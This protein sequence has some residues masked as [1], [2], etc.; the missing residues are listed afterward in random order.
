[1]KI[2]VTQDNINCGIQKD[3]Y[4]CPVSIALEHMGFALPCVSFR[5]IHFIKEP[6]GWAFF[7]TPEIVMKFIHDFDNNNLVSSFEFELNL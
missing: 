6:D 5:G 2:K 1:M 4:H 3:P 7:D